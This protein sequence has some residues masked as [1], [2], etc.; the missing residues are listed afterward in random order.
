VARVV[1]PDKLTLAALAAT[2]GAWKTGR[3]REFPLYRAAAASLDL[4]EARA[5]R[6]RSGVAGDGGAI[7]LETVP[8][9]ALFGGGTSPEKRFASRALA[10]TVPDVPADEVASRLRAGTPPVVG[11]VE[12]GKVLLD[13]RSVLPDEDAVLERALRDLASEG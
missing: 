12:S 13:L 7:S 3:W 9:L 8:S 1:R 5:E 11:R 4:L 2:L 10:V 6:I